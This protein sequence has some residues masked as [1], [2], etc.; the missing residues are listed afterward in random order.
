M[1]RLVVLVVALLMARCMTPVYAQQVY[2]LPPSQNAS[3]TIAS[4][5]TFQSVFSSAYNRHGCLIQNT[6]ANF[7]YVFFGPIASATKA[8]SVALQP[9]TSTSQGGSVGCGVGV[10]G[11]LSDQV[12]I[13]GTAAD[14]FFAQQQ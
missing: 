3:G 5:N 10:G 1:I 12:S 14:T 8:K 9:P 7:E 11:T 2:S 6:G 4:T 13:T